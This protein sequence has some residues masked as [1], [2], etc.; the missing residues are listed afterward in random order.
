MPLYDHFHPPLSDRR[1]WEAFHARWA[2]AIADALNEGGLPENH[3][4]EPT[5][6]I[7]GLVQVD[8][9]ALD[10]GASALGNGSSATATLAKPASTA[11]APTWIIPAVFPDSFEVKV[12][13]AEGGPR[14]VA[15]IELV[16]PSNKDRPDTRRAFVVKCANYLFQGIP[17][18]VVD[19]V[20]SRLSNLHNE[21]MEML[22]AAGC[23]LNADVSL[24]ATAFRPVRKEA[25]NEI[26]MWS[27]TLTLGAVLPRLPLYVAPD[28]PVLVDFEASYVET[29][30][31]LR[32][33][34]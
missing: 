8:V 34:A 33:P 12:I 30:R 20:T 26:A 7:G 22:G 13:N 23:R 19:V 1:H 14:L 31:K 21:I 17:C 15:A 2:S 28:W 3:F 5:V 24:Y 27:A 16:S 25:R 18:I 32:L 9:A 11:P 4:A 6:N 29:C 10:E